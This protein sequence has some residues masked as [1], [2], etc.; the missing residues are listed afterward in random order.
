MVTRNTLSV[1][2][3]APADRGS[4]W[5][6][7]PHAHEAFR[8]N[9]ATL[10]QQWDRL[11]MG[12]KEPYPSADYFRGL[13]KVDGTTTKPFKS[14]A[15]SAKLAADLAEAWRLYHQGEFQQATELGVSLGIA[16]YVVANKATAIYANY[17]EEN[18]RRR[19]KLLGEVIARAEEAQTVMPKHANSHYLYAYALGRYSQGISVL[20]ALAQGLGS[21]VKDAL[22]RAVALEPKH[23]D[24]HIALG[25]YH[26]EIV[27]KVGSLLAGLTYGASKEEAIKH[28][29]R[30]LSL[31]P[32]SA[33]A[34]IEYARALLMLFG[35]SK[36][37][38]AQK[39]YREACGLDPADAMERLDL[40]LA[41]AKRDAA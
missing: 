23:A 24:A 3:S 15:A 39:L 7:F 10:L 34:R 27:D 40:E 1:H 25:T 14:Q 30:A 9:G 6:A 2:R 16:G 41:R 28:Y 32:L 36:A 29:R 26:A 13:I 8:Y 12:D 38:E 17:I 33:I 5:L 22:D 19:L 31:N 37:K 11:H 18:D 21:K 20:Q 4:Q 35:E